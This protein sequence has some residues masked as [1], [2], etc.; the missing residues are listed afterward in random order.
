MAVVRNDDRLKMDSHARAVVEW[1]ES[2]A[3]MP[4]DKFFLILRMYLGEVKTPYN[5][6]NL[7][8][9]LSVFLRRQEH[10]DSIASLL[11]KRDLQILSVI[12]LLKSPD[13]RKIY[14]TL[15]MFF[16][17]PDLSAHLENLEQRLLV[18]VNENR[19]YKLNPLLENTIVP[20]LG[21]D[22]L[23]GVVTA[24]ENV[25][26]VAEDFSLVTDDFVAAFISFCSSH[27]TIFKENG[28]LKKRAFTLFDEFFGSRQN[29]LTLLASA[30]YNMKMFQSRS[31]RI[32][33]DWEKAREFAKKDFLTRIVSVCIMSQREYVARSADSYASVLSGVLKNMPRS[34]YTKKTFVTLCLLLQ[35]CFKSDAS[36]SSRLSQIFYHAD[37]SYFESNSDP[38]I[39]AAA[40][41]NCIELGVFSVNAYTEDGEKICVCSENFLEALKTD[42][43]SETSREHLRVLNVDA[44]FSVTF[45]PGLSLRESVELM[46]LFELVRYDT[47]SSYEISK[48]SVHRAFMNGKTTENILSLLENYSLYPIPQSVRVSIEE[49]TEAFVSVDACYGLVLSMD[50]S[51]AEK[52]LS[53]KDFKKIVKKE[54]APGVLLVDNCSAE[55][56]EGFGVYIPCETKKE[57]FEKESK[58]EFLRMPCIKRVDFPLHVISEKKYEP[59]VT[60]EK[61]SELKEKLSLKNL[62]EDQYE[63]LLNR[64]ERRIVVDEKQLRGD[65]VR[66]ENIEAGG[67]DFTGK[68]HIIE[69]ALQSKSLLE[70]LVVGENEPVSGVPVML[71]KG[72]GAEL[73]LELENG[74]GIRRIQISAAVYVK[75]IKG[76]ISFN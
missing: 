69:S 1:R 7:I 5:K 33:V 39:F 24:A 31:L 46:S 66:F 15:S 4:D 64:I 65:S 76:K 34:G 54:I 62:P 47:V 26:D 19:E 13:E 73:H 74:T 23:T 67:M 10:K 50:P 20:F 63:E 30:F 42:S 43:V 8:E 3:V 53:Q 71:D 35:E 45:M 14:K 48:A 58:S 41:D 52:L 16:S 2:L 27:E 44:G 59:L 51:K 60:E 11:G 18:Y 72:E 28:E 56:L 55:N 37:D 9:Q 38:E 6:Q 32:Y 75:K 49:W 29:G 25:T 21:I 17:K 70:I 12:Y 61:V 36:M 22:S 57:V 68:L 40:F